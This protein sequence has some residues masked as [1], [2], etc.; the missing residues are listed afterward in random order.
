MASQALQ[1]L[2]DGISE[3]K[4]LR[5]HVK[6]RSHTTAS[7]MHKWNAARIANRRARTVLLCSHFERFMYALNENATDFLNS[8]GVPSERLPE[9]LRLLQSRVLVDDLAKQSWEK[10]AD[11][12]SHFASEHSPMWIFGATVRTLDANATLAS[13]KSPKVVELERYFR[14]FEVDQVFSKITRS[15]PGRKRLIVSLSSLVDA[16]NGIAHGDATVQ[17]TDSELGEQLQAVVDFASRTDRL[18]AKT[19]ARLA[20]APNPW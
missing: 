7:D 19:L 10:R 2:L 11:R 3:V 20:G 8:S 9:R 5:T 17:P 6:R 18:M 1:E 14:T 13:M 16:R 12:L 15:E 4:A